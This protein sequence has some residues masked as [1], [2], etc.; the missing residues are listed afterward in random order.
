[1]AVN[2]YSQGAQDPARGE[3]MRARHSCGEKESGGR[4]ITYKAKMR[5]FLNRGAAELKVT[6][7][8]DAIFWNAAWK[9]DTIIPSAI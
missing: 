4:E 1:V 3:V 7:D 8:E 5:E 2:E 6:S 9:R